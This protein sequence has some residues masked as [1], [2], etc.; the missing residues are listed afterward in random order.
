MTDGALSDIRVLDLTCE[1]GAYCTK[2]LADLGADVIKV[3]PPGGS[4]ARNIGPFVHD[5]PAPD[6]ALHF[7]NMNTSKRSVTLDLRM[8]DGRALYRRL[9]QTAQ[10]VVEDFPPGFLDSLGVGF[11]NLSAADPALV[12]CAVTPFGQDGPR[13]GYLGPDLVAI[14]MAGVLIL[15][16]DPADPPNRLYGNQGYYTASIGAAQGVLAALIHRDNTGEGQFVD[17]SMQEALS[18]AQETAMMTWD[19]QKF[20]RARMGA[21]GL[22]PVQIPGIGTYECS[23]GH[24]Y[25]AVGTPAGARWTDLLSW[26]E[27]EG[28]AED[29]GQ[30]PYLG[31]IQ[32]LDMAYITAIMGAFRLNPEEVKPK[33][34]VL[35]H[36]GEVLQRFMLTK[37]KWEAYEQGQARRLL[38]GIVSTPQ[39][40]VESPQLNARKWFQDV[41]VDY[42]G[43]TLRFPGAPYR[44]SATPAGALRPPPSCGEHNVD[45]LCGELG[46]TTE[47]LNALTAAAVV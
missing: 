36:I 7:L 11:G 24:V 31:V 3:E 12:Y 25:A 40:L 45:V 29:L 35:Q 47:E 15:A 18:M 6:R 20:N 9:A 1:L 14:A 41:R 34:P 43:E 26:M 42:L 5:E 27:E 23:D 38:I 37:T 33:L 44:F 17:V 16:G 2:L 4:P 46:L 10:V 30:E 32:Q 21:L 8:E 19:L 13:A 39:D 22:L 28:K